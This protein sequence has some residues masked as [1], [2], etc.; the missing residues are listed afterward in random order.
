MAI[1]AN[2]GGWIRTSLL[3]STSSSYWDLSAKLA[4]MYLAHILE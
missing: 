3:L 1:S 4:D 2:H